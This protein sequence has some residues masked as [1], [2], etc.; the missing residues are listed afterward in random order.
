MWK[1]LVLFPSYSLFRGGIGKNMPK[2]TLLR[3]AFAVCTTTLSSLW[4]MCIWTSAPRHNGQVPNKHLSA[5]SKSYYTESQNTINSL[6]CCCYCCCCV[7]YLLHL[8]EVLQ[9]LHIVRDWR[10]SSQD[11]FI[12]TLTCSNTCS[13][14]Y[15]NLS[16]LERP[17]VSL[18]R[19]TSQWNCLK[20]YILL[21]MNTL[22]VIFVLCHYR[23]H[24]A[25][26]LW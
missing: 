2:C 16:S 24:P 14:S 21:C 7:M 26:V 15:F 9:I 20:Y 5:F 13:R 23:H 12:K 18:P 22:T 17:P 25:G 1:H 11:Y 4:K 6:Q 3:V 19:N 8:C 10:R